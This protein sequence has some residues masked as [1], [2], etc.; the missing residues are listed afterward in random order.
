MRPPHPAD[1]DA[2]L[3][4]IALR[5]AAETDAVSF[6]QET[7]SG[8]IEI[9]GALTGAAYLCRVRGEESPE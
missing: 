6:L 2:T 3:A 8:A 1:F 7:L 4:R 5:A 9:V